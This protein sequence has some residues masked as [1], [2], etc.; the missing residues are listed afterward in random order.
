MRTVSFPAQ[1]GYPECSVDLPY[2]PSGSDHTIFHTPQ[3]YAVASGIGSVLTG[4]AGEEKV[5]EISLWGKAGAR[6]GFAAVEEVEVSDA[7]DDVILEAARAL[8]RSELAAKRY[9]IEISGV[10]AGGQKIATDDRSKAMIT[11]AALGALAK[12]VSGALPEEIQPLVSA[13]PD[14]VDWKGEDGFSTRPVAEVLA[15]GVAVQAHVQ[16]LFSREK[17]LSD[18]L[19]MITT[20]T[21]GTLE[22]ALE[23]IAGTT[24]ETSI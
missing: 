5:L 16:P 20:E 15:A 10:Q 18:Y 6:V 4:I 23:Q 12:L 2:E 1:S 17:A 7:S 9:E 11:G 8:K 13:I 22:A 21:A 3:G 24:W 14:A 19:D